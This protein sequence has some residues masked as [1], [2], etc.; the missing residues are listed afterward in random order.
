MKWEDDLSR[1]AVFITFKDQGLSSDEAIPKIRKSFPIYGDP[2]DETHTKGVDRPLPDELHLV[3]NEFV[4][5]LMSPLIKK[6]IEQFSSMNAFL[7]HF[8]KR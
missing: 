4:L 2:T 7:R 5:E 3:I 8:L 6:E 1:L